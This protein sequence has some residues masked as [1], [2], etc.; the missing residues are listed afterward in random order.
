MFKLFY[1]WFLSIIKSIVNQQ[2]FY[3]VCDQILP[4][5]C[6]NCGN[7]AAYPI[8]L[9][10]ACKTSISH[11]HQLSPK[12]ENGQVRWQ[13]LCYLSKYR[14]PTKELI[15][16]GKFQNELPALKVLGQLLG[17][18]ILNN[19]GL[20]QNLIDR[21]CVI[22]P[23]PLH[24]SRLTSRGFNQAYE[25]AVP[26]SKIL[27]LK[28]ERNLVI[29]KVAA[30][31]QHELSREERI[32]NAVNLF[33]VRQKRHLVIPKKVVLIDDIYTT[34]ATINSLCECLI[35]AGVQSI[36]VWIIAKTL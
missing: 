15:H 3:F 29:R 9:C 24:K 26:V 10:E 2:N 27:G 32:K 11:F 31:I 19:L 16:R 5:V 21:E 6:V 22:I 8:S 33:A 7:D 1:L 28:I 30:K 4:L 20:N 17:Y 34:G 14:S 23:I 12:E 35:D 36:E 13:K 25:I 18:S